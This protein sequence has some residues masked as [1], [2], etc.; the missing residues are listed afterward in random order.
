[1]MV[2]RGVWP[3]PV[4]RVWEGVATQLRRERQQKAS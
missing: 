1:M 4:G 2:A 3:S